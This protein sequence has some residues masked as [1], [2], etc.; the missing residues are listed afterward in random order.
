MN[1]KLVC[2]V[3]VNG[4]MTP[5]VLTTANSMDQGVLVK[6]KP[7]VGKPFLM[8]ASLP[9]PDST[10]SMADFSEAPVV[11]SSA[12]DNNKAIQEMLANPD[13]YLAFL[14]FAEPTV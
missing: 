9:A 6:T 1:M 10:L 8:F 3:M 13:K 14:T 7:G 2:D 5:K 4:A 12:A 11:S